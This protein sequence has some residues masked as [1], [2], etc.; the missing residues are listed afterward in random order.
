MIDNIFDNPQWT[1]ERMLAN[2]LLPFA[3]N[4]Y[5]GKSL[6]CIF[7]TRFCSTGCPFCYYT[8]KPAWRPRTIEDQFS[9]EGIEKFIAFS[10]KAN[11]GY[12]LVSGG[13]EPFNQR[14][15]LLEIIEKVHAD[16]IVLVTSGNWA[17]NYNAALKYVQA[18]YEAFQKRTVK[19]TL[20]LRVSI[21][22]GHSIKIGLNPAR[23]LIDIFK[24][25]YPQQ[26]N[27][28]FQIKT[29]F[30]DIT[31]SKV[32]EPFI[33]SYECLAESIKNKTDNNLLV[34]K[35]P[36][37]YIL[38][39]DNKLEVVVGLS[40]I[41]YSS[42]RPNLKEFDTL[43]HS[44][45]VFDEDLKHAEDY[46]PSI[47]LNVEGLHGIDW[48]I[49]YN[50]DICTWQNQVRD[51]YMNLY[52]DNFE[53]IISATFSDPITYSF[54]DKGSC[55]RE[56]IVSEVNPSAVV[57][58]KAISLRDTSGAIIFE[59]EKTRLYMMIRALQDYIS[60]E[61]I[62]TT[63]IK[64][65]DALTK[66]I[67]KLD[68]S[69]LIS[70]FKTSKHN[71]FRQQMQR[72]FNE[73]EWIDLFELVRLKHYELTDDQIQ[74]GLEYFNKLAINP[75]RVLDHIKPERSFVNRRLTERLMHIKP[76]KRLKI[77]IKRQ[78]EYA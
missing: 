38:R 8:S 4:T 20:V 50:G 42:L 15:H 71:I 29:F 19:A 47:V 40:K 39:F 3:K 41:F 37:Q 10:E 72:A 5:N 2:N 27:F 18:I 12:L 35:I 60:E 68:K 78:A 59:E 30:N 54:I 65:W 7:L 23:N 11:L 14:K 17:K 62:Q 28:K 57:R 51:R 34:K 49:N 64:K 73:E 45:R 55:Y 33:G 25:Y 48:S 44:I 22:E 56:K 75:I 67:I 26:S 61:K 69:V 53:D 52:E 36:E 70:L 21:S 16:R 31:L 13:G 66:Q 6:A 46:N 43:R 63:D 77:T 9:D 1:R 76:L 24:K 32:L 58:M 74:E